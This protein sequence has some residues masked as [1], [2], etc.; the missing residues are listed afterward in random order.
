MKKLVLNYI[1]SRFKFTWI[2]PGGLDTTEA[3]FNDLQNIVRAEM[4]KLTQRKRFK[5]EK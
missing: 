3:S 2:G 4:V 1:T 5:N